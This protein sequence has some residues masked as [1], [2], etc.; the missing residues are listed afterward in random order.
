MENKLRKY[1]S[2]GEKNSAVLQTAWVAPFLKK[3]IN[4]PTNKMLK[5][6]E[7]FL[8]ELN[9]SGLDFCYVCCCVLYLHY[10]K[11]LNNNFHL[12]GSHI[13]RKEAS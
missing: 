3:L 6:S 11:C 5:G 2:A 9:M 10:P 12:Q 4:N 8:K 1:R 13:V 7:R